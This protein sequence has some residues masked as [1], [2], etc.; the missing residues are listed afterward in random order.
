MSK[1][2]G[3]VNMEYTTVGILI[4]QIRKEKKIK[5]SKLA[6]GLCSKQ[7]LMDIEAD[8]N[9][10][11][12]LMLDILM[13]RM[14]KSTDKFEM[15]LRRDAY[16]AIHLRDT[17]EKAMNQGKWAAAEKR[18]QNYPKNTN[19]DQMY[20]Y[21]MNASLVYHN[22][23]NCKDAETNL[24]KA[25]S[26][27]LPNF[28]Y[29]RIEEYMISTVEMENILALERMHLEEKYKTASVTDMDMTEEKQHLE[30]CMNYI[31]Q[32]FEDPEEHAK[33]YSKCAWMLA[34]IHYLSKNYI[35]T[36]RYC[37]RGIEVLRR[38]TILYFMLPLLKLGTEA[39]KA[40]GIVPEQS[41]WMQY[42]EHLMW[43]WENYAED[44]YPIDAIL[45][46]CYQRE[47]HLDYEFIR[48]ER[49][50]QK[51]TQA[52]LAD[53]VYRNTEC[54]SRVE[55]GKVSPNK[56]T[57]EKLMKKLGIDK[58]RYNAYVVTDSFEVMEIK[59]NIDGC[60]MRRNF[61]EAR[62]VTRELKSRLDMDIEENK[63]L[64]RMYEMIVAK[65]LGE[66][67]AQDA[68]EGLKEL[69]RS[70]YNFE[71]KEFSH[72]PMRNEV[73]LINN[74][75]IAL[76]E[77]GREQEAVEL[78]MNTIQKMRSSKVK[79]QYRY[80]SYAL[81]LNNAMNSGR[82]CENVY[83]G[84][85][86]ELFCGKAMQMP[87]CLNNIVHAL[88]KTGITKEEDEL[89]AKAIYYMSDL[90]GFKEEKE[91]YKDFIEKEYGIMLLE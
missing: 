39:Q 33:I 21:R 88:E 34:G 78:Y 25:I 62:E 61:Q 3:G 82:E 8:Q 75:C 20:C 36:I 73:L 57:F 85:Q 4:Q 22:G 84:L 72:I 31:K 69:A 5:G 50:S 63:R 65:C 54:L 26:I 51:M 48:A 77:T 11:D 29:A 35:D 24:Q 74:I 40:M 67:T 18:L 17:I 30:I 43:I 81:V 23:G 27:T 64:I 79:V 10:A 46:N 49:R 19:V 7:V 15:I 42:Y 44:W 87:L 45:H 70:F 2:A 58:G 89:W 9:E 91:I 37:E 80:R 86:N 1:R 13:Q 76:K 68:L 56:K 90:Y 38:N 71:K 83:E 14:G 53:D 66:M 60:L 16:D 12:I 32:H 47:Y 28:E 6:S 52:D 55:T 59:R 41:K